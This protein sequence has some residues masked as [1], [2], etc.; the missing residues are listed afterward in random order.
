MRKARIKEVSIGTKTYYR[1]QIE[2]RF[3]FF[4]YWVSV[5]VYLNSGSVYCDVLGGNAIGSYNEALKNLRDYQEL[6]G[7]E[8][9]VTHGTKLITL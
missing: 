7:I 8:L 5:H 9:E 1:P 6:Y 3:L 4:K 2:K